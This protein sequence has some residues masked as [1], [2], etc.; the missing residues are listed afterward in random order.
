MND[1]IPGE[2]GVTNMGTTFGH[3]IDELSSYPL[4]DKELILDIL[5]KRVIEEKRELLYLDY[6]A[7][8]RDYKAGKT[9]TGGVDDL[10]NSIND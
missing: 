4:Q 8:M 9:K 7:A 2:I 6:Q 1:Y 5:R 10:F 3:I